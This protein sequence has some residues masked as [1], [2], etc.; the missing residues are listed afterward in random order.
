MK[1]LFLAIHIVPDEAFMAIYLKLKQQLKSEKIRWVEAENLHIT[2]KFFGETPIE[3][4]DTIKELLYQ[5]TAN[6]T[7]FTL[8]VN[9]TGIFGSRYKPRVIWFGIDDN[10]QL[11]SLATE[12]FSR[13]EMAGFAHD[14]QNFVPHLSVGRLKSVVH[15]E[16][17]QKAINTVKEVFV[18][19]ITV[20]RITLFESLL[21]PS[22]VVYKNVE[23]FEL[24]Q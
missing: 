11:I 23:E 24:K 3:K 20:S 13:L 8:N 2:L 18:Q 22:G 7:P 15:K 16:N 14:R 6:I 5:I 21:Q 1:R 10:K 12:I 9:G 17:F 4:I 19:Q